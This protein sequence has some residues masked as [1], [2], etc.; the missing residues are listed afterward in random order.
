MEVQDA[1]KDPTPSA[2]A[3]CA[4][5]ELPSLDPVEHL[6][7]VYRDY[8]GLRALIRRR[9]HDP[10]LAEDILQDAAVTTLEKLRAGE[11]AH[12][13]NIG[14]FLFRVALNHLRNFRRKDRGAVSSSADL[15]L[16]ADH[17]DHP[18][19]AGIDRARWAEAARLMLEELPTARDRDLLVRFY[20][21][22]ETKEDI[23]VSLGLSDEHFNRV[24]FRARN[25]FRALLERRGYGKLD[26]LSLVI[27]GLCLGS[28]C[29]A[30]AFWFSP[31]SSSKWVL[32]VGA[33][34]ASQGTP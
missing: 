27:I 14:G 8:P 10:E 28:L 3:E 9:V 24:I 23:C 7:A 1:A 25:R 26:L 15:E 2:V 33:P 34:A 13:S 32:A 19:I 30:P 20:L 16:L 18:D 6:A 11:I 21:N 31:T 22:D 5:M 4:S 17:D 12:P 29:W